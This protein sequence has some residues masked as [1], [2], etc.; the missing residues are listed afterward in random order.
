MITLLYICLAITLDS[1]IILKFN[2]ILTYLNHGEN[3]A[4]YVAIQSIQF[5][6]KSHW[7]IS[8]VLIIKFDP[9]K[10]PERTGNEKQNRNLNWNR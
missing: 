6:R 2:K 7:C 10:E 8:H 4:H 1:Q 3:G 5:K 9:L